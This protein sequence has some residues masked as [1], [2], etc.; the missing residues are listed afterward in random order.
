MVAALRANLRSFDPV[1]RYGGD[2]FVA[3]MIGTDAEEG[4]RR[5]AAIGVELAG[6]AGVSISYGLAALEADE[7]VEDLMD[8]ADQALYWNRAAR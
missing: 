4:E 3:G 8:R 1:L 7:S 5:F 2:E 6:G